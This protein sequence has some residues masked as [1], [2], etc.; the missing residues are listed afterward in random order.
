MGFSR[1]PKR[2]G[3]K[4]LQHI[5]W[6]ALGVLALV[7]SESWSQTSQTNITAIAPAPVSP[8]IDPA[9]R[10]NQRRVWRFQASQ[11]PPE[12]YPIRLWGAAFDR[13][14]AQVTTASGVP[15]FQFSDFEK[16]TRIADSLQLPFGSLG[17]MQYHQ[18]PGYLRLRSEH[19]DFP[20]IGKG[21]GL[22]LIYENQ[23][24]FP[25]HRD[26]ATR[27]R[28]GKS[29]NRQLSTSFDP[30]LWAL[31]IRPSD[32]PTGD[33]GL[34]LADSE[35]FGVASSN[36]VK[37]REACGNRYIEDIFKNPIEIAPL[38]K[39]E[40]ARGAPVSRQFMPSSECDGVDSAH[41]Y[42][43]EDVAYRLREPRP[44]SVSPRADERR[45]TSCLGESGLM[46]SP[47]LYWALDR[48]LRDPQCQQ[49]LGSSSC[50]FVPIE[51]ES[52]DRSLVFDWSN[53]S[54]NYGEKACWYK[55]PSGGAWMTIQTRESGDTLAKAAATLALDYQLNPML[56]GWSDRMFQWACPSE[57]GQSAAAWP[58]M[59]EVTRANWPKPWLMSDESLGC[60]SN[61]MQKRTLRELQWPNDL[62]DP[63]L[64]QMEAQCFLPDPAKP[65]TAPVLAD[66]IANQRRVLDV[67]GISSDNYGYELGYRLNSGSWNPGYN[68]GSGSRPMRSAGQSP[69]QIVALPMRTDPSS[70]LERPRFLLGDPDIKRTR[71]HLLDYDSLTLSDASQ[72]LDQGFIRTTQNVR[73]ILGSTNDLDWI[74]GKN[75]WFPNYTTHR[76]A[77]LSASIYP[78]YKKYYTWLRLLGHNL[79]SFWDEQWYRCSLHSAEV[80]SR[81]DCYQKLAAAYMADRDGDPVLLTAQFLN[82]NS[83]KAWLRDRNLEFPSGTQLRGRSYKLPGD[84]TVW[85]E[86]DANANE[87][88]AFCRVENHSNLCPSGPDEPYSLED[89]L[90][91]LLLVMSDRREGS[92]LMLQPQRR[93]PDHGVSDNYLELSKFVKLMPAPQSPEYVDPGKRTWISLLLDLNAGAPLM[94]TA[95]IMGRSADPSLPEHYE[96][97]YRKFERALVLWNVRLAPQRG[98]PDTG[99]SWVTLPPT[100]NDEPYLYLR[101]RAFEGGVKL[102]DAATPPQLVP[103][104]HDSGYMISPLYCAINSVL[105]YQKVKTC[106]QFPRVDNGVQAVSLNEAPIVTACEG[107]CVPQVMC[108]DPSGCK[109]IVTIEAYRAGETIRL[110]KGQAVILFEGSAL[111]DLF[112]GVEAAR[113]AKLR[114]PPRGLLPDQRTLKASLGETTRTVGITLR[115]ERYTHFLAEP[116]Y[117]SPTGVT[118]SLFQF[119]PE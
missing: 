52:W 33:P 34:L 1:A 64:S 6:F 101:M 62:R 113:Y 89:Q 56:S 87:S 41:T 36:Q 84:S 80:Y 92:S 55:P 5:L 118:G 30:S 48:C 47:G 69:D 76:T 82:W 65:G 109:E 12:R 98:S 70:T 44:Q 88:K 106:N 37:P 2:F 107:V 42:R 23:S 66:A 81:R 24:L 74:P 114:E 68:T 9:T 79:D 20:V 95:G 28:H 102:S 38:A 35:L 104:L 27:L 39:I 53:F 103:G 112:S 58:R 54:R 97:M 110:E 77:L 85:T 93:D 75:V 21:Y 60:A 31:E 90:A 59:N 18:D 22:P 43:E 72:K 73:S 13:L 29:K 17:M 115:L 14:P 16:M 91:R 94:Q 108:S 11:R 4:C 111:P 7:P 100:R 99:A 86:F 45:R 25:E 83:G 10:I 116:K 57:A 40:Q 15:G 67:W 117:T 78:L 32:S 61:S 51:T 71:H 105:D 19:P 96:V 50:A 46:G 49:D 3:L 119:K 8:V 63:N 26:R